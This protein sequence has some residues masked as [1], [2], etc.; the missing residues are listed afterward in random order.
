MGVLIGVS[1]FSAIICAVCSVEEAT[2][3]TIATVAA[4][5]EAAPVEA[6]FTTLRRGPGESGELVV[7][8][9]I[10][11]AEVMVFLRVATRFGLTAVSPWLAE[12][13][14]GLISGGPGLNRGCS[15]ARVDSALLFSGKVAPSVW[16]CFFFIIPFVLLARYVSP[17]C[18][19]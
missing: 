10:S 13:A 14:G 1:R 3:C 7:A 16:I 19:S 8:G 6:F 9:A 4:G 15:A 17:F 18:Q 2:A 11:L 5:F 12:I